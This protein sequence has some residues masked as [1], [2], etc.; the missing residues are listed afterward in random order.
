MDDAILFARHSQTGS[1][2][3]LAKTVEPIIAGE[4][5]TQTVPKKSDDLIGRGH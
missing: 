3:L 1:G 2:G 5:N 4:P